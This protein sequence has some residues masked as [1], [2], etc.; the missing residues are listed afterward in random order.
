MLLQNREILVKN[1][2]SSI[3]YVGN[4]STVQA[5]A[6]NTF[7]N[8]GQAFS[9]TLHV[10][11]TI[12][13]FVFLFNGSSIN[14]LGTVNIANSS[15]NP[16]PTWQCFLDGINLGPPNLFQ[17]P[18]NN[19]I[20][21]SEASIPDGAHEMVINVTSQGMPFYLDY[22]RYQPS[23]SV[24]PENSFIIVQNDD[25]AID[26]ISGWSA[27]AR[28]Q[29]DANQT[30]DPDGLVNVTFVGIQLSW[31]GIYSSNVSH[32]KSSG[33]YSID[34]QPFSSFQLLGLSQSSTTTLFN[35]LLFITPTLEMGS[36][37]LSA[38]YTGDTG[39]TPLT[40]D[41]LIVENGS[42]PSTNSLSPHPTSGTGGS[43][44]PGTSSPATVSKSS[45]HV[46][47]II[48]GTVGAVGSIV[49]CSIFLLFWLRFWRRRNRRRGRVHSILESSYTQPQFVTQTAPLFVSNRTA[50]FQ[51][52]ESS[53]HSLPQSASSSS[54]SS[55]NNLNSRCTTEDT[56]N[57][58]GRRP[59]PIPPTPQFTP[60]QPRKGLVPIVEPKQSNSIAPVRHEDSGIRLPQ[61]V[62]DE[63]VA[64]IL[65]PTYSEL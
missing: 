46:G 24:S 5:S 31:Y 41:Y 40:L 60:P 48:G 35:Q 58:S 29:G 32:T 9:P 19:W 63:I 43:P 45:S 33:E 26:Y 49:V 3:T 12:S 7:G 39:Q 13:S 57:G 6:V 44:T 28:P 37:I 17:F 8:F 10:T 59:L 36:H 16:N 47:T 62:L 18:E 64:E 15:T 1:D 61:A 42:L 54:A 55:S 34:G 21:C 65:L 11:T 27:L 20:L 22:V 30:T 56:F 4:W 51:G 2:D 23:P 14:V 38:R 50:G 52:T 53:L 25:R